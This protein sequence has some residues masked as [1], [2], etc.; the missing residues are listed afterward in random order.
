ML[1]IY[2]GVNNEI[3][4]EVCFTRFEKVITGYITLEG[5]KVN[6]IRSRFKYF[7]I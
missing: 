6:G 3:C 4:K 2:R 7:K 5:E 1:F